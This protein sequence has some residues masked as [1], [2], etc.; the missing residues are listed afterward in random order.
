M[1]LS[2]SIKRRTLSS[3]YLKKESF[4]VNVYQRL[5]L[6]IKPKTVDTRAKE[7]VAKDGGDLEKTKKKLRKSTPVL[8]ESNTSERIYLKL[9]KDIPQA[10]LEMLFSKY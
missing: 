5:F 2:V 4:S 1:K 9:F 7:I 8:I 3:L 6:L 10:D